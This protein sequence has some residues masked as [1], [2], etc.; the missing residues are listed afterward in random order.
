MVSFLLKNSANNLQKLSVSCFIS[1]ICVTSFK[2]KW[3][4]KWKQ[5]VEHILT[6][7]LLFMIGVRYCKHLMCIYVMDI[8][9]QLP[10]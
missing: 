9:T 8:N 10:S 4:R 6:R 3:R 5:K 7:V 1:S 2:R